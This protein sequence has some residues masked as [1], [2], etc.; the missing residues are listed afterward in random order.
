VPSVDTHAA[1]GPR[2]PLLPTATNPD[3]ATTTSRT[4]P[5]ADCGR[6]WTRCQ[7]DA[8]EADGVAV[9]A[10]ATADAWAEGDAIGGI[11]VAE[12][13]GVAAD[14]HP[15]RSRAPSASQ[16]GRRGCMTPPV[17]GSHR[18][19]TSLAIGPVRRT[20]D[21]VGRRAGGPCGPM[22]PPRSAESRPA[23]TKWVW[24]T[25]WVARPGRPVRLPSSE[26]ETQTFVALARPERRESALASRSSSVRPALAQSPAR[27]DDP[28]NGGV[29]RCAS[30]W[31]PRP[32][33]RVVPVFDPVLAGIEPIGRPAGRPASRAHGPGART[34]ER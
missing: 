2:R 24:A 33:R 3:P 8:D 22:P 12:A 5:S 13:D 23:A 25:S 31:E 15:A 6:P 30:S 29:R 20:G 26:V 34:R 7:P 18:T 32:S 17:A 27:F 1:P 21:R 11:V 10:A 28:P 19:W 4:A 14:P 16:Y 9:C